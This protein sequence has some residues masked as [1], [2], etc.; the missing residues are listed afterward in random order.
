MNGRKIFREYA[1]SKGKI[2]E[3]FVSLEKID[4]EEILK[5]KDTDGNIEET[6]MDYRNMVFWMFRN[7]KK[8]FK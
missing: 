5:T 2:A 4:K 1:K 7:N 3:E 8:L 6:I